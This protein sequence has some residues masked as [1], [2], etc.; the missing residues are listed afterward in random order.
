MY[1]AVCMPKVYSINFRIKQAKYDSQL[2]SLFFATIL[3]L[4]FN[5]IYNGKFSCSNFIINLL[6]LYDSSLHIASSEIFNQKD[7][8]LHN[9]SASVRIYEI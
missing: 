3:P 6:P 5:N 7:F 4:W 9:S 8:F 2:I 1:I